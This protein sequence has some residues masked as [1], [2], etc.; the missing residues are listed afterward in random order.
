MIAVRP[1]LTRRYRLLPKLALLLASMLVGLL[2][3]EGAAR[4]LFAAP[5]Y[6]WREPQI[7]Y[8]ADPELGFFHIPNQ[9]GWIEDGRVTINSIGFRGRELIE[10]KPANTFRVVVLGDSL[11]LG[12]GVQDDETYCARLEQKIQREI[13]AGKVCEI[14]N[15][16][17]GAYDTRREVA[18]FKRFAPLLEPDLILL[19]FYI[20]DVVVPPS[21][22]DRGSTPA[23][24]S[25]QI[26]TTDNRPQRILRMSTRKASWLH[27]T[28]RHSRVAYL[29]GH[30]LQRLRSRGEFGGK[31]FATELAVLD[32]D[33]SPQITDAWESVEA[34]LSD[35]A[36]LGKTY[37][38]PV[39]IVALPCREQV[40]ND[41]PNA[42]YQSQ[43]AEIG[44][45]LGFFVI[46]PLPSF[47]EQRRRVEKLFIPYDRHHPTAMGHDLIADSICSYL[48]EHE[49]LMSQPVA[50]AVSME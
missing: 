18:L 10:P 16:G 21:R 24:G 25:T 2:M 49:Q 40:T 43:L 26:L 8:A 34:D 42:R 33:Q 29:A 39:G 27:R 50:A 23:D 32:G 14:V 31:M 9:Q 46:D 47:L 36:S 6:P 30:G 45:R 48:L 22:D 41:H 13:P 15:C 4:L 5:P 44:N 19:G 7:L 20:N 12:W 11:T 1:K 38:V 3:C 37:R 17:V 28:L 35:L